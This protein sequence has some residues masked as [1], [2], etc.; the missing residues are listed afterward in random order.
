MAEVEIRSIIF[1]KFGVNCTFIA[2]LLF[3]K[4]DQFC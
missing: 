2:I 1:K 4:S 3:L